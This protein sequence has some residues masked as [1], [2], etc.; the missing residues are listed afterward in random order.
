MLEL[1]LLASSKMLLP[2]T[3][4]LLLLAL[5][6]ARLLKL[7]RFCSLLCKSVGAIIIPALFVSIG[8]RL[9]V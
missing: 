7:I 6:A 4:T 5:S 2:M 9:N 8:R 1:L 3:L